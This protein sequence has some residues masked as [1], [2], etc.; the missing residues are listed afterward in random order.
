VG[1]A[2]SDRNGAEM[3][4]IKEASPNHHQ[5]EGEVGEYSRREGGRLSERQAGW[6]GRCSGPTERR[7]WGR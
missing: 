2:V 6:G 7:E 4:E 1:S 5:E 3:E